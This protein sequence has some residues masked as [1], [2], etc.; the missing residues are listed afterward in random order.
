M[1]QDQ[2][3]NQESITPESNLDGVITTDALAYVRALPDQC[4]DV[5]FTDSPYPNGPGFFKKDIEDAKYVLS[6]APKKARKTVIFM[7]SPMHRRD[8]P[9]PPRGWYLASNPVWHKPD[10]GTG[11]KFEDIYVW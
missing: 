9:Q 10:A 7:W 3:L 4:F 8:A 2:A 6:L 5:L 11:I 1:E